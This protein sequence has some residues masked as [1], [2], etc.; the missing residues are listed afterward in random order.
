MNLNC[1]VSFDPNDQVLKLL[2]SCSK[3]GQQSCLQNVLE[4]IQFALFSLCDNLS[5]Q[6]ATF[7][8]CSSSPFCGNM[9]QLQSAR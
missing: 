8:G 7:T 9:L 3:L 4:D 6:T 2:F 5:P 1:L